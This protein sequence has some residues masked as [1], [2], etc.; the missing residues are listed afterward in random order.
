[1]PCAQVVGQRK[2]TGV[3]WHDGAAAMHG[4]DLARHRGAPA[5]TGAPRN[6]PAT[7]STC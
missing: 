3:V 6:T 4:L 1:M 2:L 7:T 5:A